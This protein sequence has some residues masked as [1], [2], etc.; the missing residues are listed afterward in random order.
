MQSKPSS[1]STA[2]ASEKEICAF[3]LLCISIIICNPFL[4]RAINSQIACHLWVAPAGKVNDLA[5][6]R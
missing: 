1:V 5:V 6:N 3:Q 4:H 2:T